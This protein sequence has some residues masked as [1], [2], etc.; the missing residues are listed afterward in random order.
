MTKEEK[1][2]YKF[3]NNAAYRK[4]VL[5]KHQK[6]LI[7]EYNFRIQKLRYEKQKLI[8]QRAKEIQCVKES[9]WEKYAKGK[10]RVNVTEGKVIINGVEVLFSDIKKAELN[11][12]FSSSI[13]SQSDEKTK[14]CLPSLKTKTHASDKI[15]EELYCIHLGVLVNVNGFRSEITLLT[16]AVKETSSKY[17]EAYEEAQKIILKLMKISKTAVPKNY[18]NA[19][20]TNGVKE[21]DKRIADKEKE[22]C[23]AIEDKPSYKIP[24]IYRTVEQRELSDEE[25]LRYLGEE[26]P[27]NYFKVEE[28]KESKCIFKR[29]WNAIRFKIGV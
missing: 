25:Y 3:V 20:E 1:I 10:L 21:F 18:L 2:L 6:R 24:E 12:R 22:I 14:I 19:A 9:R 7:A 29:F 4:K 15:E 8:D 28:E 17:E 13:L 27:E 11:V 26:N 23:A 5:V 16:D